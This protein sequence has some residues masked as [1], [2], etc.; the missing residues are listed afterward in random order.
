MIFLYGEFLLGINDLK[1]MAYLIGIA[2]DIN[3]SAEILLKEKRNIFWSN[4]VDKNVNMNVGS[5]HL[6]CL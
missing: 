6:L 4:S 5:F 2:L 1:K 3:N